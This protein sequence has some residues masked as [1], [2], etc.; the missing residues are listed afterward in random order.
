ME[1]EGE[2]VLKFHFKI[3]CLQSCFLNDQYSSSFHVIGKQMKIK[4][5]IALSSG[6][7]KHMSD[8][9]STCVWMASLQKL[10][11]RHHTCSSAQGLLRNVTLLIPFEGLD[12]YPRVSKQRKVEFDRLALSPPPSPSIGVGIENGSNFLFPT[13]RSSAISSWDGSVSQRMNALGSLHRLVL[14]GFVLRKGTKATGHR[15]PGKHVFFMCSKG[16][17]IRDVVCRNAWWQ[18]LDTFASH[19]RRASSHQMLQWYPLVTENL[20]WF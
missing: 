10:R 7:A 13:K 16:A 17:E 3:P 12:H 4:L 1:F 18:S 6:G 8:W 15:R 5:L 20:T 11:C 9:S 14:Y 19:I 2:V